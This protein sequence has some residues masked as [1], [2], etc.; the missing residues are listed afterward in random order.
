MNQEGCM[1]DFREK[2]DN[3]KFCSTCGAIIL[4]KAEICPKCGVRQAVAS[5]QAVRPENASEKDWITTLLFAIF[6]W[7]FGVHRFY[8]GKIGTGILM[9][10]FAWLTFGI[11]PL[12]DIIFIATGKFTDTEGKLIVQK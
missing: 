3:E 11:W 9:L 7:P 8:V 12:I 1:S 5:T 4:A 10:L 2:A 6:L